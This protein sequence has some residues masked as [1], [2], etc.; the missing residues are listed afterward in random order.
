MYSLSEQK[1]AGQVAVFF[2]NSLTAHTA[3]LEIQQLVDTPW[4]TLACLNWRDCCPAAHYFLAQN[5][6]GIAGAALAPAEAK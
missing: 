4:H 2:A 3:C 5:N 6:E 1:A